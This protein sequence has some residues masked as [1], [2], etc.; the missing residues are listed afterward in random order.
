MA[1]SKVHV[2]KDDMVI[3]IAG[4]DK[5]KKG[6]VL[7]VLSK[8]NRV[9]VEGINMITKHAKPSAQMQQGGIVRQEGKVNASNVMYYC[10]K[11]KTGVRVGK[12][13]LEDGTKIRYCKKCGETFNN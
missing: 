8:E 13:F 6:K 1:N 11:D 10:P 4:K 2:K 12:K 7:A 3:V 5:G 9:I